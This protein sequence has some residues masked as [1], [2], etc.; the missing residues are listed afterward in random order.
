MRGEGSSQNIIEME[1]KCNRCKKKNSFSN[2]EN[3]LKRKLFLSI[4]VSALEADSTE[5]DGVNNETT[6]KDDEEHPGKTA[7]VPKRR[8][9]L[10]KKKKIS[11]DCAN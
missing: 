7:Q 5:A 1:S 4:L 6:V 10:P 2:I 8:K 11:V 3:E 9:T